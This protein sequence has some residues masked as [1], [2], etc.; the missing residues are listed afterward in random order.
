MNQSVSSA[1]HLPRPREAGV[2][3]LL[4]FA[5]DPLMVPIR[6]FDQLGD[7]FQLRL[8]GSEH[9]LTRDPAW[10]DEV[11]VKQA[12]AFHKDRTTKGLATL[13]G[14]GLLVRDGPLWRE[15]RRLLSPPFIPAAIDAQLA[16]FSEEA[17]RELSTWRASSIVDLHTAMARLTM[18]IALRTLFGYD[19]APDEAFER[20]MAAAMRYFEGVLG[21]QT[22]LPTW[23]PTATN[24]AFVRARTELTS[25]LDRILRTHAP[26]NSVLG[27]LQTAK[28][29]G[30]LSQQDVVD[31][32]MTMLVA[33]HETAALSLTYLLGELGRT[34]D[35]QDA[36]AQDALTFAPV[37]R[38][39]D[40]TR[41]S[42]VQRAVLEGLRLYPV[43][44]A[45]GREVIEPVSVLGTQLA[46]GTQVYLYQW[47]MQ[48]NERVY[49]RALA[50]W[51]DR[52]IE[53][54]VSSL[55]KGAF[56]PFGGGPRICIGYQFALAEIATIL[57][58]TLRR[59][60]VETVSPFPPRLRTSI[61]A[62]PRDP[63]AIRV[64]SRK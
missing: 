62:R 8:F 15:R 31:E 6:Y 17:E 27:V 51:P 22:P 47:A 18:R 50:F 12:K 21:T 20:A 23:V 57:L 54:P 48:R 7:T 39:S 37:L 5:R 59:Y 56:S 25:M 45:T 36:V 33:G 1:A 61:T 46:V 42:A 35:I 58:H 41:E 40:L 24:R 26:S 63:V 34:K 30:Q 10:F 64:L 2:I 13:M 38:L 52:F 19:P 4:K 9:I 55:P 11:Q 43:A 49:P 53:Q 44:W 29:S 14:Q 60:R 32:A 16:I 3:A 28:Q